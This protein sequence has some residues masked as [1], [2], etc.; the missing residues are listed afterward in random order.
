MVDDGNYPTDYGDF[1]SMRRIDSFV[2]DSCTR[3]LSTDPFEA[4]LEHSGIGFN[5]DTSIRKINT[6]L[7]FV[8]LMEVIKENANIEL[9]LDDELTHNLPKEPPIFD[10]KRWPP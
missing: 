9:L 8:P 2:S 3:I 5:D 1:G 4:Y 6:L 10:I 7:N